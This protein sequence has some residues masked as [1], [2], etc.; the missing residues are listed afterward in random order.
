MDSKLPE[1]QIK[2][3][4]QSPNKENESEN[5]TLFS[6]YL[7]KISEVIQITDTSY[8]TSRSSFSIAS[9][10]H[11]L[12]CSYNSI[13]GK[14]HF[15]ILSKFLIQAFFKIEKNHEI[16]LIIGISNSKFII[17]KF[18]SSFA[19]SPD[20]ITYSGYGTWV[21]SKIAKLGD[22]LGMPPIPKDA[23]ATFFVSKYIYL[24]IYLCI[25]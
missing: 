25:Y 16:D 15:I 5:K 1:N 10:I 9:G 24:F 20:R 19:A 2:T 13:K 18:D 12:E 11:V 23:I 7:N 17:D 21:K 6:T 22:Q 3:I 4:I 8:V 14:Q